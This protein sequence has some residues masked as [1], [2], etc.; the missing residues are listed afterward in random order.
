MTT[1]P[2][3]AAIIGTGGIAKSHVQAVAAAGG[4]VELAAAVDIDPDRVDAFAETHSIPRRYTDAAA[5]LHQ[6]QPSLVFVATP[7]GTHC[8]LSVMCLEAGAWV[9]CEKPL[10]ASLAEMDRIEEAERRTGN[11]CSS[12]FQWRFGSGGRHLKRLLDSGELGRPLVCTN[13][14]TWYR[15]PAY[16]AVPWRGKWETELGG[17]TMGHGIHAMDFMLWLLGDW[18]EV[19]AM[20]GTL[21]REIEVEDVSMV[22]VRFA[23]GAMASVVNSVLSPR[24]ESF[25][26]LDTQKATV[27]LTHLY[28]Y[29]NAHWRY[30]IPP[31][32][33]YEADLARWRAI[34]EDVRSSHSAQLQEFLTSMERNERPP[35]SGPGVRGTIEY[36]TSL[37]KSA[38]TGQPV[39]RGSITPD[40]PF[41]HR[42][43]GPCDGAWRNP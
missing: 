14:T 21:D 6:E 22:I 12:V 19:R 23:N 33:P 16:Y 36:L 17:V 8:D 32:A 10:C 15:T 37:Y 7:P 20:I 34:P 41:Y 25:L 3:R 38:M 2:I 31:G 4:R 11:Y 27:E 26:R 13:L 29:T 9:L 18:Q 43:C 24:E 1:Q 40:D 5:M 30:S 42:M 28:S 35:V 39:R